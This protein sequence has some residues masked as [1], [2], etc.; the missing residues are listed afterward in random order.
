MNF[1]VHL[2][3]PGDVKQIRKVGFLVKEGRYDFRIYGI[4]YV[5]S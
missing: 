4:G 5:L 2:Q 3:E 1:L